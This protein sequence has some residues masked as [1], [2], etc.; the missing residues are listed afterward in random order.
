MKIFADTADTE[1]LKKLVAAGLI[2]GVTTNPSIIAKSGRDL[3]EVIKEICEICPGPISA[4]VTAS[5]HETML[6]EAD[7]L[8]KIADNIVIK[9]PLTP[10]GLLAT[11]KLSEKG[12]KTNVTLCF[13]VSQ[14]ILAAKVGATYISPFVGRLDDNNADGCAL[15]E[16]II[17]A[18]QNYGYKTQVLA[19]SIRN[20]EHVRRVAIAG[21]DCATIPTNVIS[22][23]FKHPLTDAGLAAFEKDWASTGQSILQYCILE[24][25]K[26]PAFLKGGVFII[27][28]D[29]Y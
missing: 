15:I 7:K 20:V 27:S 25:N 26:N 21:T 18:Y 9:V 6:L 5:D 10:E 14:A 19:A 12:V 3:F 4:E 24:I 13:S 11:K 2:D 23:M 22:A 8:L 16:D 1:V 17:M 29:N 28:F